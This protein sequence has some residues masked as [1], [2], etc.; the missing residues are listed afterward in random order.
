MDK[1]VSPQITLNVNGEDC[2]VE[3]EA[4]ATLL[5]VLR[6]DLDLT[7]AKKACDDGECGSCFVMLGD[8]AVKACL[9]KAER[10]QAKPI[11]TIEGLAA[12][13]PEQALVDGPAGERMHALQRAF[14]EKGATQCGF[15]IPGMIV[16]ANTLL[17]K[18]PDPSREE[19]IGSLSTNLCRCTG[20]YKIIEAVLHAADMLRDGAAPLSDAGDP[21]IAVGES[22]A[23]LDSPDTVNGRAKYAADLKRDGMLHA[24]LL[25]A[26]HH[27][28]RILSIDTSEAEKVPGVAAVVT[29]TDVPGTP[30]LSNCQPQPFVFPAD[31]VRFLGEA[32]AAVAAESETIAEQTAALIKVEYEPLPHVFKLADAAAE[33]A[34]RLFDQAPNVSPP[35]AIDVGDVEDAFAKADIVIENDYSIPMREHAAMEPEAALAHI[36]DDGF[37]VIESPLYHPFVQGQESVAANLDWDFDKVRIVCPAMGGNF[38]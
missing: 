37:M 7:G 2:V 11:V 14:L 18:N 28:A 26:P 10:G 19:V 13:S 32:V 33:D 27:H 36:D 29:A 4:E 21:D 16:K 12:Q 15:C 9:L 5:D 3:P 17:I 8:K 35:Q 30:W 22:V 20:Y 31:K 24:K 25:R 1:L 34:P 38:V 23:R 6:E